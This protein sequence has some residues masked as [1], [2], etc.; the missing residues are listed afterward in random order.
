MKLKNILNYACKVLPEDYI[1]HLS[2]EKGSAW[3][4]LESPDGDYKNI[5]DDR[6]GLEY[7]IIEA[8]KEALK[9][10][11]ESTKNL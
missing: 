5:D 11:E 10:H 7:H 2:M 8:V 1:V 6:E 9:H 4:A 3:V